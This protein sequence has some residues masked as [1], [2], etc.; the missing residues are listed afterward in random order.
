MQQLLGQLVIPF[1]MILSLLFLETS[2]TLGQYGG[3]ILICLACVLD[4]IPAFKTEGLGDSNPYWIFVFIA[5]TVPFAV[6]MVYKEI[7][8]RDIKMSIFY[9]M[10]ADASYQ[11]IFTI[12]LSPID[13]IPK[14]GTASSF[15]DVYVNMWQGTKCMFG[16]DSLPGDTCHNVYLL[17]TEY[18]LFNVAINLCLLYL[19][20]RGSAAFMFLAMTITVPTA[21]I[22]FTLTFI[23]GSDAQPLS[24]WDIVALVLIVIGLL[25]YRFTTPEGVP[26]HASD[27]WQ[28][29]LEYNTSVQS[30]IAT[31]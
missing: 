2:Y 31:E 7:I 21:N 27:K 26:E 4:I 17:L 6:S 16:Y 10:A 24:G 25:L 9:L 13:A 8:F 23:M 11:L 29:D 14:V 15:S 3:A 19:I 28:H 30:K 20:Q 1:S 22:C 18:L 12:V 5:S